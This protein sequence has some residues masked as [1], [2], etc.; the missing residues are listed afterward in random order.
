MWELLHPEIISASRAIAE[1]GKYD[2]AIFAAFRLVEA[3]VQERI[4]SRS[5]GE[6]LILEA[7]DGSP[8]KVDISSDSRD[9]RGL[10]SLFSGVKSELLMSEP[11]RSRLPLSVQARVISST[12]S[13][14]SDYWAGNKPCR[15]R[16][17]PL[18]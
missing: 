14:L 11:L 12:N 15:S 18:Y 4:A 8:P 5:I 13:W 2:D 1:T 17:S 7:F 9:Q 16:R 10:V 6:S 3:S